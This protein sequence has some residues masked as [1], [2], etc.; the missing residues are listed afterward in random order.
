MQFVKNF[1]E[2][3]HFRPIDVLDDEADLFAV[4]VNG[5]FKK[6]REEIVT[7][8][9][10][11]DTLQIMKALKNT[12]NFEGFASIEVH[13]SLHKYNNFVPTDHLLVFISASI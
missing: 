2:I 10:S 6:L 11:I 13:I 5:S 1:R 9:K 4:S 12:Q 7:D 8:E 3:V